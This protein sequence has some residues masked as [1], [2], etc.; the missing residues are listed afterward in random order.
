M[1]SNYKTKTLAF[2]A[3]AILGIQSCSKTQFQPANLEGTW[4][5]T[6]LVE[7]NTSVSI[8]EDDLT[9]DGDLLKRQSEERMEYFGNA[10][11]IGSSEEIR[12][13]DATG[14]TK[15]ET[16]TDLYKN[17]YLYTDYTELYNDNTS[18][19]YKD[20]A[21]TVTS[22]NITVVFN[23]DKTFTLTNTT[24]TESISQDDDI[25]RNR[26]YKEIFDNVSIME[27][28]WAFI[29]ADKNIDL[30]NKERIGLWF[31]TTN[32][33]SKSSYITTFVDNDLAD[34][35]DYTNESSVYESV[36]SSTMKNTSPDMVWEMIEGDGKQMKVM[37]TYESSYDATDTN[38][39]TV[40][41][42]TTTTTG[43]S[44]NSETSLS[45]VTMSK[46]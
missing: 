3:I 11:A 5:M 43:I 17:N 45:T 30:K 39:Y 12:D 21:N 13:Y 2:A 23:K 34:L 29:G 36:A 44:K 41:N 38:T 33:N 22:R 14:F 40:G 9:N 32:S 37:F 24:K 31:N 26:T 20:T 46:N 15:R 4:S 8:Y 10:N 42:T 7:E 19:T 27:G 28:S 16:S 18:Y 25:F 35:F 1:K 6:S